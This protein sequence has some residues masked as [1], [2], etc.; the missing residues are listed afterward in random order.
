MLR[1]GVREL[2]Q[3]VSK[4]LARVKAGESVEITERGTLIALLT[5]PRPAD[6]ARDRL[7]AEGKLLPARGPLRLPEPMHVEGPSTG[8]VLDDLRADRW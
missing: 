7:V 6:S 3:N 5:P 1:V 8:E 4:Y 2:R